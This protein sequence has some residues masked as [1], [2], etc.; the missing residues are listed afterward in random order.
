MAVSNRESAIAFGD[1]K[2]DCSGQSYMSMNNAVV[3][4]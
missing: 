3:M 4:I 2:V 1:I